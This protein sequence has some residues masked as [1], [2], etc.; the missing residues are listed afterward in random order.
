MSGAVLRVVETAT[1]FTTGAGGF[2]F[3]ELGTPGI[4]HLT[5]TDPSGYIS[6]PNSPNT[7][8]VDLNGCARQYVDFGDVRQTCAVN[9]R[10]FEQGPPPASGWTVTGNGACNVI[11]NFSSAWGGVAAH[12]GVNT[13][14][15]GGYCSGT[16]LSDSVAQSVVVPT[17]PA[18]RQLAFWIISRRQDPDDPT[19]D[20][21]FRVTINNTPILLRNMR[22]AD[23]TYPNWL[24]LTVDLSPYSGQTV[25]LKFLVASAGQNTGNILLDDIS[26]GSCTLQDGLEQGGGSTPPTTPTGEA[27]QQ[28][29]RLQVDPPE[30]P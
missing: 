2:Y 6:L 21:W 8:T 18:Q 11:G 13:T 23:N 5:E 14:W 20:D 1:T 12:H 9:D 26:L 19:P 30:A 7:R 29:T 25:A 24:R 15:L 4:Y 27:P 10:S 17:D 3:F 22:Q 28:S 16:P